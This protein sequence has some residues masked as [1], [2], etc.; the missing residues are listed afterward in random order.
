MVLPS[1]VDSDRAL[2]VVGC[3]PKETLGPAT[4]CGPRA[5]AMPEAA[6]W[7]RTVH[8]GRAGALLRQ[9]QQAQHPVI[10]RGWFHP[11][12]GTL[13]K[14]AKWWLCHFSNSRNSTF[15]TQEVM[16]SHCY[17]PKV[18]LRPGIRSRRERLIFISSDTQQT[19][20]LSHILQAASEA[21]SPGSTGLG[22]I[23]SASQALCCV[24]AVPT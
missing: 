20:G 18:S 9:L 5:L 19:S 8:Q 17:P 23:V 6:G 13:G 1:V 12:L 22:L 4:S 10:S 3:V 24:P 21:A 2:R 15:V 16:P 14:R 11:T 7:C